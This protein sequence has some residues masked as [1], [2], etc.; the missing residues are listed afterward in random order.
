[1]AP[2]QA[3]RAEA[4]VEGLL[5]A[6]GYACRPGPR[7]VSA[8]GVLETLTEALM[9]PFV[10][11]LRHHSAL[12]GTASDRKVEPGL[13]FGVRLYLVAR[14]AGRGS[15]PFKNYRLDRIVSLRIEPQSFAQDA[16]FDLQ[17]YAARAFGSYHSD[18]EC[19]LV[20]LQF[21]REAANVARD[22]QF[23]PRQKLQENS[24]GSLVVEFE[25]GGHLELVWHLYQWGDAVEV[26]E[27][28][29]LVRAIAGHRG[30]D[31]PALP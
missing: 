6:W 1:M 26:L 27:P 13:L 20:R 12:G 8:P 16:E 4:N 25:C 10:V 17:T 18:R 11:S 29:T 5:D 31:F 30:S 3:R 24:D 19:G 7:V 21:L 28:T 9:A 14:D 22:L 15:E 23:H 2:S